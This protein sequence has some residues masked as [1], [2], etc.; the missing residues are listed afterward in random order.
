MAGTDV[1]V[2]LGPAD[3]GRCRRRVHLDA[4]PTADR[5]VQRDPDPGLALRRADLA[6]HSHV[7]HDRLR[8]VLP[9]VGGIGASSSSPG[10]GDSLGAGPDALG[11]RPAFV[12]GSRLTSVGRYGVADLLVRSPD[13]GYLPVLVRGHRTLDP[14]DGA[15]CSTFSDPLRVAR[16]PDRRMRA[17]HADGL[18]LAHLTRLLDDLG[19]SSSDRRG[20]VIGKGGPALDPAWDDGSVIAWHRLDRPQELGG[21]AGE[22]GAGGSPIGPTLLEEYDVRF[23]DRV[24]VASAAANGRPA[25]AAP[26]RISECRR[27]PWWPRCSTEL[28]AAHDVSLV[29]AGGDV[30]VL[31]GAG[32]RTYDDLAALPAAAAAALPLTAIAP[33]EARVRAIAVRDGLPLVRR[34]APVAPVRA[35]VEL[36]IDMESYLD[37]GA[38]LWGTYLTGEPLAGFAPGYRPFVTWRPLADPATGENFAEFWR[39]LSALRSAA[40]DSGLSF[41]AYCYS[42]MAEER[43]LY[44][45][46]Q[47]FPDVPGVPDTAEI[48]AFCRS[49]QWVDVYAE[50][51]QWFVVPGSLRLKSVAGVAGFSWRDP[52][53]SGENSMAWYRTAVSD[54]DAAVVQASRER[55]LRYNED[56]VRATLVLR[57]WMSDDSGAVPTIDDLQ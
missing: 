19:L 20:G 1:E 36:D 48:A 21:P 50:V 2:R 30:A 46:P 14:G 44:G 26:S 13:G 31:R 57:R 42:R 28:E 37:D 8:A 16:R 9:L 39:Y 53:P 56:D 34:T 24:A 29:V 43:W 10:G 17:H 38:Y 25:L 32:V 33:A 49:P 18:A 52:E 27:C 12:W 40:A 4:D 23:A 55:L 7:V 54:S 6:D 5:A 3:A 15:E 41:A 11:G 22:S 47:R 45:T 51:R 35:D